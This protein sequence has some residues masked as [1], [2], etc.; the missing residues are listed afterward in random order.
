MIKYRQ[1]AGDT[2]M[3]QYFFDNDLGAA[4]F[5]SIWIPDPIDIFDKT[6]KY[7]VNYKRLDNPFYTDTSLSNKLHEYRRWSTH[8]D[9]VTQ[10]G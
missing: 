3:T 6:G 7:R 10:K 1:S 5:D 9:K 4:G 8:Y 2:D